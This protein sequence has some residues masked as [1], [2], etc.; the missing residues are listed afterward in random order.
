MCITQ[1][2]DNFHQYKDIFLELKIQDHFNI[3]KIHAMDHYIH[4][5]HQFSTADGFNTEAPEHLHIGYA[6]DAYHA[7]NKCDYTV[8]M[9]TWL[10]HQ[11]AVDRFTVYLHWCRN[12][13]YLS[14]PTTV[15]NDGIDG[16]IILPP[17]N[18]QWQNPSL[19][20]LQIQNHCVTVAS[21]HPQ[22]LC[23]IPA[24]KLVKCHNAQHF[25]DALH[26]F[27]H[28]RS[29]PM[30]PKVFNTFNLYHCLT[31][32]LP[33]I[34]EAGIKPRDLKNI[35]YAAPPVPPHGH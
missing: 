25:L 22:D 4:L 15:N 34:P 3:L 26:L 23:H 11:E 8:Q 32:Q 27:L 16:D 29:S 1:A 18:I 14:V 31:V 6:K 24:S 17:T 33:V 20:S 9:T 35:I 2:L 21:T 7:S 5:I 28:N 12:R 13:V 30:V 19:S 10:H